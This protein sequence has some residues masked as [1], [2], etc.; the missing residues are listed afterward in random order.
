MATG[1]ELKAAKRKF[2]EH[3]EVQAKRQSRSLCEKMG[4]RLPRELRNMVYDGLITENN[5]TSYDGPDGKVKLVNGYSAVQHFFDPD[6]T[7]SIVHKDVVEELNHRKVRFDFRHRHTL[8]PAAFA[9]YASV[10]GFE[11]AKVLSDVGV[12]LNLRDLKGRDLVL[13]H[14]KGLL[15]LRKGAHVHVFVEADGRTQKQ[16]GRSFRR[17]VRSTVMFLGRLK[18]AGYE[19]TVVMNPSYMRSN[20]KNNSESRFSIIHEQTFRY[21]FEL[22]NHE[23]SA[24]GIER[25]LKKV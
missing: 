23:Y 25:K 13:G 10:H 2:D 5:A 24:T 12:T 22:S 3:I 4:N 8:L 14:L 16:I 21:S 20:V 19:V 1:K 6:F 9:Q 18:Q 11:L 17:V 7:G 15:K